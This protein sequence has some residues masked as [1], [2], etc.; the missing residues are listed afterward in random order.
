MRHYHFTITGKPNR[1]SCQ[2]KNKNK[3]LRKT[4]YYSY[5]CM[6]SP[7]LTNFVISSFD[8]FNRIILYCIVRGTRGW[9][10]EPRRVIEVM[11]VCEGR[12]RRGWLGLTRLW[13]CVVVGGVNDPDNP[14]TPRFRDLQPPLPRYVILCTT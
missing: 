11:R 14:T 5:V 10:V 8:S 13:G 9:H 3:I 7:I 2:Y 6:Q 12:R 1:Y 4:K